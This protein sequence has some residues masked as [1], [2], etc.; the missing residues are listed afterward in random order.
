MM[1]RLVGP[2]RPT[3]DVA[4]LTL[5]RLA[6]PSATPLELALP[7]VASSLSDIRAAVKR[8]LTEVGAGPGD[9]LDL[10]LAVGEASSNVVE[11]AYGPKGGI[12][13]VRLELQGPD[14]VVAVRD[15]GRWRP[16][17]GDNR[18]RGMPHHPVGGRRG[19][20]RPPVGRD[21]G[22]HPPPRRRGRLPRMTA[23]R[24]D[25]TL[26]DGL[27]RIAVAG[28]ID[29]ANAAAVE[30]QIVAAITNQVTRVSVELGEVDYLDSAG[31]RIFFSLAPR[32]ST[33]QI[34]LELAAPSARHPGV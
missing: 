4:L 2:D 32:L 24:V 18:G 28:E 8:W 10:L 14:V 3:D 13:H 11:H 12:V 15:T 33:L 31:L 27:V 19:P 7:A 16:P 5:R 25:I 26:D 17:R 22:R 34:A 29:L 21:R 20:D 9:V 23:A 1:V 6:L 30:E